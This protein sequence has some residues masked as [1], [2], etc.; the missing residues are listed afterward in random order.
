MDVSAIG[1]RTP[2]TGENGCEGCRSLR[3]ALL[4]QLAERDLAWLTDARLTTRAGLPAEA[5]AVHYGTI[6]D[7]VLAV[8]DE[9]AACL[10]DRCAEVLTERT[11]WY[12]RLPSSIGDALE[13]LDCMPGVVRLC[14]LEPLMAADLRLRERSVAAR[15]RFAEL[16]AREA[17]DPDVPPLH[18]EFLIGALHSA[19]FDALSAGET[20]SAVAER[21]E[22][23]VGL[24]EP[25]AA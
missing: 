15:V 24:R 8:Y 19:A 13:Q 14:F 4:E 6:E 23:L 9:V 16:L 5:L 7:C 17:H 18:F 21:M 20:L 10:Y 25:V 3:R 12:L 2:P 11:D 22:D 1:E